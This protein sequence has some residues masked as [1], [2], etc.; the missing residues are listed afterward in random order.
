MSAK[1]DARVKNGTWELVPMNSSYNLV[2]CKWVFHTKRLSNGSVD[3]YKARLVTKGF[4]QCHGVDCHGT[5]SLIF[6]AT[7]VCLIFSHGTSRGWALRQID[8]NN[9]F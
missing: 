4:H 9:A 3:R 2:G 5:F 8:V 7:F 6:K 1:Y